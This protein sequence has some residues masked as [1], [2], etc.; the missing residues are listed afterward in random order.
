M[1]RVPMRGDAIGFAGISVFLPR[2][3]YITT[4]GY[5]RFYCRWVNGWN[6]DTGPTTPCL[7]NLPQEWSLFSQN[8]AVRLIPANGEFPLFVLKQNPQQLA[9]GVKMPNLSGVDLQSFKSL[10]FH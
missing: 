1:Y 9:P 10:S 6:G 8:W 3:K 4:P 2:P 5:P 7:E